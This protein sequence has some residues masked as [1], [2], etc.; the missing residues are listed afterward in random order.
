MK[1]LLLT[2]SCAALLLPPGRMLAQDATLDGIE[3]TIDTEAG[4]AAVCGY[5]GSPVDIAIPATV[6]ID[7]TDYPVTAIGD[8]AFMECQSLESV[9]LPE[10]VVSIGELAFD[11]C[12]ALSDVELPTGLAYIGTAA[13]MECN[14]TGI[15]IPE[16]VKA[17]SKVAFCLC[18]ALES[19]TL[20]STLEVIDQ[21]AFSFCPV[22]AVDCRAATPPVLEMLAFTKNA[23]MDAA[24]TVPEGAEAAYHAARGWMYF[25]E[26]T[27]V[28][29]LAYVLNA[30]TQTASLFDASAVSGEF[31]V[32][33]TVEHEGTAYSVT[34]IG[35]AAFSLCDELTAV[36][37]PEGVTLI[38]VNAFESCIALKNITLPSTLE[39]LGEQAFAGCW[40]LPSLELPPGITTI[41]MSL[42]AECTSFTSYAVPEGVESIS[43]F[44]F[45][46]CTALESVTLPSTLETLGEGAFSNC[47]LTDVDCR[48]TTPPAMIDDAFDAS[49]YRDAVLHVPAGTVTDYQ[50]AEGWKNFRQITD[51]QADAISTVAASGASIARYDDAVVTTEGPAA[52]TVYAQT[53]AKALHAEGV[54]S[55][56]LESLPRGLYIICVKQGGQRQTLK[57]VR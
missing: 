54:A 22:K 5:E 55:L 25:F 26:K 27:Q 57:A 7:G 38:D 51:G 33:A 13:F 3:Y 53:G 46:A 41:P 6:N 29:G 34:S 10:G 48:A 16:G 2:L 1:H 21:G 32:P 9:E 45:E 17:I 18:E 42:F 14:L 37:V 8:G 43:D 50:S 49:T 52:I 30:D 11:A 40:S 20:P 47:P 31:A 15:D 23:Y 56:S 35:H 24:L 36:T 44:A 39:T 12:F 19:V 28:D 4:T